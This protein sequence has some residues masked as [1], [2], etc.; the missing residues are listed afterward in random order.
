[1]TH[2]ELR[3]TAIYILFAGLSL[4]YAVSSIPTLAPVKAIV[5]ALECVGG[6]IAGNPNALCNLVRR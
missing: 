4:G 6:D 2:L 3:V 5:S 1:M